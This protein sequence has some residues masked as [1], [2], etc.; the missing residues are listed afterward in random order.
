[1]TIV[2]VLILG[3]LTFAFVA[4]PLIKRGP[5]SVKRKSPLGKIVEEVVEDERLRELYSQRD[6]AYSMIKELKF[7][8]QS[9]IL[10]D[11]DYRNLDAKYKRKAISILR[12]IENMAKDA[13]VE[14]EIE[15]QVQELL[16]LRR[17][18]D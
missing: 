15:R 13:T 8:F 18:Q 17:D 11:K 12:D 14:E 9:G 16:G 3:L 4:N 6:T 7:D 10:N 2:V 1:M 5:P